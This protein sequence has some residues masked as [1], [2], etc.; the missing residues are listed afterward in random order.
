MTLKLTYKTND[1][2]RIQHNIRI[3]IVAQ[4]SNR[5]IAAFHITTSYDI[6]SHNRRRQSRDA[7]GRCSSIYRRYGSD[8]WSVDVF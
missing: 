8:V 4:S 1:N 5:Y 2:I 7:D 3:H 6:Y